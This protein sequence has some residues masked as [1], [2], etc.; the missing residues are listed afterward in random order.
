MPS[1]ESRAAKIE[2]FFAERY[3]REALFV[4]SGRL[5]LLLAFKTWLRAGDRIL[6]S[7]VTDDVVFF[8]VL[9]A[10]L[11]PVI[12]PLDP[13]TGNLDFRAVPAALWSGLQGV[14][15]TNLYGIPDDMEHLHDCCERSGTV[16]IEDACHALDTRLA[17]KRIGCFGAAA[18]FSLAK[19]LKVAGGIL[20]F[21]DANQRAGLVAMA[22]GF[23]EPRR[24]LASLTWLTRPYAVESVEALHLGAQALRVRSALGLARTGH[25]GHRMPYEIDHVRTA[26]AEPDFLLGFRRWLDMDHAAWRMPPPDLYLGTILDRLDRLDENLARRRA[27]QRELRESGLAPILTGLPEDTALFRV[28][29]FVNDRER[30]RS[31]CARRGLPVNYIYDPPLDIYVHPSLVECLPSPPA[32]LAWSREVL[33]VDPLSAGRF[34]SAM[35]G[36][37][38]PRPQGGNDLRT[39]FNYNAVS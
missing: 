9:A 33:P 29:L 30:A 3:G 18:A 2:R 21:A 37:I 28:P 24:L 34:L 36:P 22:R 14:L 5:A 13:S 11:R 1:S 12:G 15:T 19:H 23:L 16:Q 31:A 7:P 39:E 4:P 8:L 17:G 32:A 20:I 25:G 6:M 35:G 27:G 38:T 26:R 10:G